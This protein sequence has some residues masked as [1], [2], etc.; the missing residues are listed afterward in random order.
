MNGMLLS[1]FI[2]VILIVRLLPISRPSNIIVNV[3]AGIVFAILGTSEIHEKSWKAMI[4]AG[5]GALLVILSFI[6]KLTTGASYTAITIILSLIIIIA[7]LIS[8][9]SIFKKSSNKK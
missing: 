3:I 7:S 4:V 8:D 5:A 6:P 9:F 1:L 2:G